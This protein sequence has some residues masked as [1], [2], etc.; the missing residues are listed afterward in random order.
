MS[1]KR[2]GMFAIFILVISALVMSACTQSLSAAPAAT[3]T[4]LPP[5]LFVSPLPSAAN[6]MDQIAEF[7]RQ[8][9][10]AQTTVANGG[11]PVTTP[12]TSITSTGTVIT[13]E[14]GSSATPTVGVPMQ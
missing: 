6:P 10:A 8:T 13:P 14:L 3:P 2:R 5:E 7:A 12:Q 4:L 11:T 1:N 9:A